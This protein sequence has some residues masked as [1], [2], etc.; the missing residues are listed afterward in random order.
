MKHEIVHSYRRSFAERCFWKW[1]PNPSN[2]AAAS[3]LFMAQCACGASGSITHDWRIR[4]LVKTSFW[5]SKERVKFDGAPCALV[6]KAVSEELPAASDVDERE[7]LPVAEEQRIAREY[8]AAFRREH[9]VR[10]DPKPGPVECKACDNSG[11]ADYAAV[12][13]EACGGAAYRG[14]TT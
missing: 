14:K 7:E 11:F 2:H 10:V 9:G 13:C 12:P 8:E 4:G 5:F 3:E 6:M 1:H